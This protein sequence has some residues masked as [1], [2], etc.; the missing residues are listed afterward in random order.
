MRSTFHKAGNFNL[1]GKKHMHLRCGCCSVY[2]FR[3]RELKKIH[4]NDIN[5]EKQNASSPFLHQYST[6]SLDT[7]LQQQF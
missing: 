5:E 4:A 2:N 6:A 1:R 3:E 7:T